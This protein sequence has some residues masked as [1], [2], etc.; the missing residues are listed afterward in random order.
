MVTLGDSPPNLDYYREID[1]LVFF[2][3]CFFNVIVMFS[4]L[5][6]VIGD[7]YSGI[8]ANK[9]TNTYKEKAR[10]ISMIQDTLLGLHKSPQKPNEMIFIAKVISSVEINDDHAND[11][12]IDTLTRHVKSMRDDLTEL[13][14]R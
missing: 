1:W 10:Q 5:I 4:L 7:T 9:V 12:R 2:I 14:E 3:C 13:L 6:S 8:S 11:D